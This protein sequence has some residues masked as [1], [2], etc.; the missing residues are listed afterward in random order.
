MAIDQQIKSVIE[1]LKSELPKIWAIP[2][3]D[4]TR[5]KDLGTQLNFLP[6]SSDMQ[7]LFDLFASL[8]GQDL[9]A[10]PYPALIQIRN[11]AGTT[12]DTIGRI[13]SFSASVAN[14]IVVRQELINKIRDIY[15]GLFP[16]IAPVVT[17]LS[18]KNQEAAQVTAK[19]ESEL[20]ML[21]SLAAKAQERATDL[22]GILAAAKQSVGQLGVAQHANRFETEANEHKKSATRWLWGAGFFAL[23]T[24]IFGW[25]AF[26]HM[27]EAANE[28][29]DVANYIHAIVPRIIIL[30]LLLYAVFWCA[31]N[32]VAHCHN[33]VVN[34]HRQNSLQTFETFVGAATD[35]STK[36]AVLIET[37][38]SIFEPQPTG[39]S[40]SDVQAPI[41]SA[42][43]QI[44]KEAAERK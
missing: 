25:V 9:E 38:H 7:R 28:K 2:T 31:R 20:S 39:Y 17:Y 11:F 33:E 22:E 36:D 13:R 27:Y 19:A 35:S 21:T 8:K 4:L 24:C 44:L 41:P 18:A 37:T 16:I 15:D 43:V 10:V 23:G 40:A 1:Q 34:R 12:I 3:E 42:M 26:A 5:I 6:A 30:S 29:W 32:Y 14:P